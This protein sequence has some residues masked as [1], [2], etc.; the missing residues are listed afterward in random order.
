MLLDGRIAYTAPM[1]DPVGVDDLMAD[2]RARARARVRADVQAT[3]PGSP[4][5]DP[6]VFDE[7]EAILRRALA[8]RRQLATPALLLDE[9]DWEL[10]TGLRFSS[11]RRGTGGLVVFAK[12]RLLLPL[13]R[14]LF[15]YSR[16]NFER[17][18]RVNETLMACVETLVVE[19][20]RLR[21]EVEALAAP[22]RT[23]G[24][25]SPPP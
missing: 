17:Q 9:D 6:D 24:T 3:A 2:V 1:P 8:A 5:A 10:A 15:E 22:G 21:R 23:S 4:L 20:V 18:A 25:S 7:A 12:R 16:D 11:H 19:I 13:T 14:W